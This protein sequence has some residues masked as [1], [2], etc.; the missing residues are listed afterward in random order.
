M[1]QL[2]RVPE[3]MGVENELA[4]SVADGLGQIL[5]DGKALVCGSGRHSRCKSLQVSLE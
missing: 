2:P 4:L 3:L 5:P 1:A